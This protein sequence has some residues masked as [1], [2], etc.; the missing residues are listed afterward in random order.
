MCRRVEKRIRSQ[1]SVLGGG[2]NIKSY[3]LKFVD[4]VFRLLV[5]HEHQHVDGHICYVVVY[6]HVVLAENDGAWANKKN[7]K[8]YTFPMHFHYK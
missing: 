5:L 4:Y 8:N 1:A 6:L 3:R 7:E 2:C